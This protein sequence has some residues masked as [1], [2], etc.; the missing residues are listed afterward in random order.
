MGIN[1]VVVCEA[2]IMAFILGLE[3]GYLYRNKTVV[4]H[5]VPWCAGQKPTLTTDIARTVIRK[6][7]GE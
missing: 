2:A 3:I 5:P 6:G 7:R 4:I 1:M